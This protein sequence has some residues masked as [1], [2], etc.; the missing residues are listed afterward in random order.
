MSQQ[1]LYS[2]NA[3]PDRYA[4]I[5]EH[6]QFN[7]IQSAC[8]KILWHTKDSLVVAAPTGSG[9]TVL[10]ELA[11]C[12][13]WEDY[14]SE[15]LAVYIAPM[16]CL[17]Q[18]KVAEWRK[19]FSLLGLKVAEL[20]GDSDEAR[21]SVNGDISTNLICTTPEKWDVEF[22]RR[23]GPMWLN[24]Q[25]I[26]R[27]LGR[28]VVW[29]GFS[30]GAGTRVI[31][32]DASVRGYYCPPDRSPFH[33]DAQLN[34]KLP[35]LLR[36]VLPS[37]RSALIGVGYHNAG[38]SF[39]DRSLI[40]KTFN[41]GLVRILVCT[42]TLA[43]GVNLPAY[44]VVIRGTTMMTGG[45]SEQ[46][47]AARIHQMI[48]R[49][50]RP[51]LE[52]C[53]KAI[54]MT[55]SNHIVE[56]LSHRRQAPSGLM[57]LYKVVILVYPG[58]KH[59]AYH[60][61][62]DMSL[63]SFL[64]KLSFQEQCQRALD[65]LFAMGL[66]D[67]A[68]GR[69]KSTELG[70]IFSRFYMSFNG[71]ESFVE[72]LRNIPSDGLSKERLL[73]TIVYCPDFDGVQIRSGEK[74]LLR[75]LNTTVRYPL[76][77]R[78]SQWKEKEKIFLLLQSNLDGTDVADAG[79]R[80]ERLSMLKVARRVSRCLLESVLCLHNQKTLS[81]RLTI[82]EAIR[83]YR[84]I[85][86]VVLVAKSFECGFWHNSVLCLQQL[87]DVG[88]TRGSRLMMHGL[89]SFRAL[90]DAEPIIIEMVT[91]TLP[92]FGTRLKARAEI[93]FPRY[94]VRVVGNPNHLDVTLSL[95]NHDVNAARS[96]AILLV[97]NE[98]T[99]V[100][101]LR[102]VSRHELIG[103]KGLSLH[104]QVTQDWDTLNVHLM[105]ETLAGVDVDVSVNN[106][107]ASSEKQSRAKPSSD[108]ANLLAASS[109]HSSQSSISPSPPN[110]CRA[111]LEM[112]MVDPELLVR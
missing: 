9:K 55:T 11:V 38:L 2:T 26:G 53:G 42:T 49:A 108:P 86:N 111:D 105:N 16:K 88:V 34:Y 36:E 101:F 107:N 110:S 28:N 74:V 5:F 32:V 72:E 96:A 76:Q 47:S 37:N 3:L 77:T 104:I 79:P 29:H 50:G 18:Q 22:R 45:T 84:T 40:E 24:G 92:P 20:T 70:R 99:G 59:F 100:L 44:L 87:A 48:G 85:R 83:H 12:R 6:H 78:P 31:P 7:E 98:K 19:K 58:D 64:T 43:M 57:M 21:G 61:P 75:R 93:D 33:F 30:F 82:S 89:T 66:I 90:R 106:P 25:K 60:S 15:T 52:E 23:A 39:E 94:S 109:C 103:E 67:K 95:A 73:I 35:M 13:A 69:V 1:K 62:S 14:R 112:D 91:R 10:F 63:S 81:E 46:Y 41:R 27:W 54:I 4:Q 51:G 56:G 102:K 8:L 71:F 80:I 17:V 65:S 68:D 97:G